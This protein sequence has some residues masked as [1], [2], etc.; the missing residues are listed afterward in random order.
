MTCK[1]CEDIH[2]AQRDG[3]TQSECKCTCHNET[4][5]P[6]LVF[7]EHYGGA[8]LCDTTSNT[9]T[10]DTIN[11]SYTAL[12]SCGHSCTDICSCSNCGFDD[13]CCDY[14]KGKF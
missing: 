6:N 11:F 9:S 10:N 1:R 2:T 13:C 12:N 14:Q 7:N 5:S 4:V 3:K 8:I